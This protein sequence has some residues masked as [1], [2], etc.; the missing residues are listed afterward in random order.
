[1]DRGRRLRRRVAALGARRRGARVPALLRAEIAGY[2]AERRAAGARM[3]AI[4]RETGVSPESVR[5]W[6]V[7]AARRRRPTM[8]AVAVA[9]GPEQVAGGV[10]LVSPSGYRVE[11]LDVAGIAAV[12][13]QLA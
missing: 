3:E 5:R 1:M 11:G 7:G 6:L 9:I 8:S 13:R 10:V 12:L 2:A 4:A